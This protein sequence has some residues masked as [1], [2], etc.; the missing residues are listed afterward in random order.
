MTIASSVPTVIT[1]V[2]AAIN[3]ALTGQVAVSG[4]PVAVVL[5]GLG[6]YVADE[7]VVLH[8]MTN[9]QQQWATIGKTRRD[10]RY[11]LHGMVRVYVGN[12]DQS[13]CMVRADAIYALIETAL[14]NDPSVGG[15]VNISVQPS[16]TDMRMDVTDVGGRAAELDFVLSVATQ[17]IAT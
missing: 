13:Y 6:T 17:L 16:M 14:N 10:E 9:G 5:G 1:A 8:G 11:D 15:A 4:S 2:L 12:D 7:F 3:T